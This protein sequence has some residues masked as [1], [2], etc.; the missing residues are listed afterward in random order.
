[1]RDLVVLASGDIVYLSSISENE[2]FDPSNND[3]LFFPNGRVRRFK[4]NGIA[5]MAVFNENNLDQFEGYRSEINFWNNNKP[6]KN[7]NDTFATPSALGGIF[8][9]LDIKP[10][11]VDPKN[12]VVLV[13]KIIYN[14]EEKLQIKTFYR[15]IPYNKAYPLSKI[16][17]IDVI[18]PDLNEYQ[19]LD[20]GTKEI[21][22]SL[23]PFFKFILDKK[24]LGVNGELREIFEREENI[25]TDVI[26][27]F[28]WIYTQT[29]LI[30]HI[31]SLKLIEP[32]NQVINL[33]NRYN[34]VFGSIDSKYH[35]L[36]N[37]EYFARLR[38]GLIEFKYW[39]IQYS[40]DYTKLNVNDL[41]VYIVNLFDPIELSYLSYKTKINLLN[42]ILR[43]NFWIIG[44]WGFNK[45]NDEEA[46]L[47]I[48][49]AIAR[50]EANGTLNYSE[51]DYFMDLLNA[52][53][54]YNKKLTLYEVLYSR[55]DDSTLLSDDGKGNKG[56]LVK[57][58]YN[59]WSESK[60]NPQHLVRSIAQNALSHFEYTPYNC[61]WQFDSDD[62]EIIFPLLDENAAPM[63]INY[64]SEKIL[65]WYIDNFNFTF[66]EN[67]ILAQ[68]KVRDYGY[69]PFGVYNIFQPIALRATDSTD[70]IIKMPV[71]GVS[72]NGDIL[73]FINNCIPIFYLQYVDDL[74]D[75]SDTKETIGT[76]ADVILTFSGL[77]GLEK[78]RHLKD[79]SLLRKY[80]I[81]GELSLAEVAS[82][83]KA[84]GVLA[85]NAQIIL[86]IAG[87]I[88]RFATAGCAIYYNSE[89]SPP[90]ENDPEYQK[91]EF[92]KTIDI[93]L[94]AL[95]MLSLS[96]DLL[97]RRAFKRA[98]KKLQQA[99][100]NG[101]EYNELRTVINSLDKI[102]DAL[103]TWLL[104][105]EHTHPNIYAKI[106]SFADDEKKIAFMLDFKEA[107]TDSLN[108]LNSI[109]GILLERW[110]ELFSKG[111]VFER[112]SID[113]LEDTYSVNTILNYYKQAELKSILEGLDVAT[114]QKLFNEFRLTQNEFNK[115]IENPN[116]LELILDYQKKLKLNQFDEFT[117]LDI[118]KIINSD[119]KSIHIDLLRI[120]N[121]STISSLLPKFV[122]EI[123]NELISIS[124]LRDLHTGSIFPFFQDF[125][126]KLR[127]RF[128][129]H[130]KL[131]VEIQTYNNNTPVGQIIKEQYLSGTIKEIKRKFGN[132]VSL[133]FKE[134]LNQNSFNVFKTKAI[135][136]SGDLRFDDT[137]LKFI[138][139]FLDE[140]WTK[141]NRF[142]INI[143]S[144]RYACTSCQSY[145]VY[146]KELAK[147]E[148]K[149][150]EIEMIAHPRARSYND[151]ETILKKP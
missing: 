137:E 132:T 87:L 78:L 17:N 121:V 44:N 39:L 9:I 106:I 1:M 130:N 104:S 18:H 13:H 22:E 65:L 116:K 67:K 75:Y 20:I 86:G 141:G 94:F 140:H 62:P 105:L 53:F 99:I 149:I 123:K 63:I 118:L 54:D 128:K 117:R 148:G 96:G 16:I 23:T 11:N 107:K 25:L 37:E 82:F 70:T 88:Q 43:D 45:L 139:N 10:I 100:P 126:S 114:R 34:H 73:N 92:C 131:L 138:F 83:S 33:S 15:A 19:I 61:R 49:R 147:K 101:T 66:Y 81:A 143:E 59:L 113:F 98:T 56:Q 51:I 76:A 32:F 27:V 57:V 112:K 97:A 26:Q 84:L 146:L 46:I 29:E 2:I 133:F 145:L 110:S 36:Y 151:I 90:N 79:L 122:K 31:T 95:E 77:T 5:Y 3:L 102:E 4:K 68:E 93:W 24:F 109:D 52:I 134:P 85:N 74:G 111:V 40:E 55:I 142:V 38:L 71:K 136:I 124:R 12:N 7:K 64:E 50:E 30:N 14:H 120:K 60:F 6:N 115:L 69:Q 135:D 42:R 127:G 28:D 41:I 89:G 47:K 48:I 58:I 125:N 150:L 119:L 144:P 80:F 21:I 72:E 35:T 108:L 103:A 8:S 129:G 91:F